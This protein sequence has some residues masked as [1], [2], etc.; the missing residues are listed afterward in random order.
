MAQSNNSAVLWIAGFFG[1]IAIATWFATGAANQAPE[2]RAE[3]NLPASVPADSIPSASKTAA[4]EGA[5]SGVFRIG[6]QGRLTIEHAA[7][8]S[9]GVLT[10]DLDLA[11]EL[12]SSGKQAVR[13][14]S[15]DGRR[16]DTLASPLP[17][18]ES[19][20]RL[21]IEPGFLTPGRYMIEIDTEGNHPLRIRRYVLELR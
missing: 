4:V 20:V 16:I 14:I 3:A 6:S 17:G 8:P 18:A 9:E 21:E 2:R 19:G 1:L 13:V 5:E 12:R 10:L 11:D 7:L 15:T